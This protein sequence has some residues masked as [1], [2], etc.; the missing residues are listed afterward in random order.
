MR[1]VLS[2]GGTGGHINPAISIAQYFKNQD[3]NTEILFIGTE[4]GL[5]K[6]LI[7]QAGFPIK[8]IDVC[9]F[10]RSLSPKNVVYACKAVCAT[11]K[12][13]KLL[14][15]YRP[16]VV[17]GTGG[18]VSGPVL[19][20]AASL[21]IP[22]LIHEQN[23]IPG[24][25]VKL[26]ASKADVTATSFDT[27]QNYLPNAKKVVLTGNPV[28]PDLLSTAPQQG[29]IRYGFDNR[30]IVLVMSGSL[31][32]KVINDAVINMIKNMDL[33]R[34]NLLV[35]TGER[36]Y[37]AFMEAVGDISRMENVSVQPYIFEANVAMS[38]ADLI[39]CRTGAITVSELCAMGKPSILIPSANVA[40][41]HQEYN[42]RY[43]RDKGAARMI[44][45]KD[46]SAEALYHEIGLL[47]NDTKT[48]QEMGANAHTIGTIDA[49][50]KIYEE[51]SALLH[52]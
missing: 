10:K 1:I 5:E 22:T 34:F 48:L 2:G 45:D 17:I 39:V 49:C 42:A 36:Y 28:R 25:T 35:S 8:Y 6:K 16:D 27:T 19:S 3:E 20:A 41:N 23:V 18:Y 38:A 15:E 14:R 29:R 9:G 30:P 31:G 43:M 44:L 24:L 4:H 52:K 21:K 37:D 47:I 7:P 11:M 12:A 26:L 13:K 40:H 51:V 50:K 32:A 33:S 46:A